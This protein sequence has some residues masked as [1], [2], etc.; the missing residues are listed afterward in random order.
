MERPIILYPQR[1]IFQPTEASAG[2]TEGDGED[3]ENDG[4]ANV[5]L[6]KTLRPGETPSLI[7]IPPRPRSSFSKNSAMTSA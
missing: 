6:R 2:N 1:L 5:A 7:V 4:S 3:D